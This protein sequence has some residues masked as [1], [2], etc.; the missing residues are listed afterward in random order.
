MKFI[1]KRM[2]RFTA[3]ASAIALAAVL[4][5]A[6]PQQASANSGAGATILNIV[7]VNYKD[8]SGT[9]SYAETATA[10]VTVTLVPATPTVLASSTALSGASNTGIV[11]TYTVTSAA[12]GS[13]AYPIATALGA[14]TNLAAGAT[15]TPSTASLTLGGS[16]ITAVPAVNQ[17]EIPAGTETNI[18]IGDILVIGGIDY[19]TSAVAPGNIATFTNASPSD[20]IAGTITTP[21]VPTLITLAANAAAGGSNTTPAFTVDVP[22]TPS[23]LVGTVVGEQQSFTVTVTATTG[24]LPGDGTQVT[25]VTIGTDPTPGTVVSSS[26]ST[27]QG[28]NLSITKEV[29]SD[30]GATYG[31]TGGAPGATLTY[32]ITIKN[33]GAGS[34]TAV[35]VTD[36]MPAFTTYTASSAKLDT[37]AGPVTYAAAATALTDAADAPATDAFDFGITTANQATLTIG[38]MLPAATAT[39]FYQVTIQ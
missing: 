38:T 17:I 31:A 34:A 10:T 11:Y 29:S 6:A 22:L 14:A 30:G 35:I 7:T 27:F 5:M 24:G 32:R 36:P 9:T 37:T 8:A 25:T 2:T 28:A 1:L 4:V 23:P 20:G 19:Y 12:N 15:A 26:T 3:H 18:A 33:N 13:D 21:A 16:V 39:L